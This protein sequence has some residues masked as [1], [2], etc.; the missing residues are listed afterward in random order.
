[1]CRNQDGCWYRYFRWYLRTLLL[2]RD[3]GLAKKENKK[4]PTVTDAYINAGAK[5]TNERHRDR[6]NP[7][8]D[9]SRPEKHW[10]AREMHFVHILFRGRVVCGFAVT[11]RLRRVQYVRLVIADRHHVGRKLLQT[12]R[13]ICNDSPIR[14]GCPKARTWRWT[15]HKQ[16]SRLAVLEWK[17]YKRPF[18]KIHKS[19]G[20]NQHEA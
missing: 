3:V 16:T 4:Q 8:A 19:H 15:T 17:L 6:R 2:C 11:S 20:I 13:I 18:T 12:R 10:R 7:Y 9:E 5:Q 14:D 1:M